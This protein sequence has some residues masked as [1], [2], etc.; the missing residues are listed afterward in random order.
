[1]GEEWVASSPLPVFF[2]AVIMGYAMY[3]FAGML[4][5][6]TPT[7]SGSE[8]V[9]YKKKRYLL[10]S[11]YIYLYIR[12]GQTLQQVSSRVV[13]MLLSLLLFRS[14]PPHPCAGRVVVPCIRRCHPEISVSL[15]R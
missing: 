11:T 4:V 9:Q 6:W 8:S 14:Q 10:L 13:P 5:Q 3:H 15:S 7:A 2:G 1:M 12:C